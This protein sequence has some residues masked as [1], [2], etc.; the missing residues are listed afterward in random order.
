MTIIMYRSLQSCHFV[1][2]CRG[3][4]KRAQFYSQK[5]VFSAY[6]SFVRFDAKASNYRAIVGDHRSLIESKRL[7]VSINLHCAVKGTVKSV[8]QSPLQRLPP[9][10]P[11]YYV[12]ANNIISHIYVLSVRKVWLSKDVES[13]QV[14]SGQ[15]KSSQGI[16]THCRGRSIVS[17]FAGRTPVCRKVADDG[18]KGLWSINA[19]TSHAA[20]R[21]RP[22]LVP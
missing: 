21:R 6:E 1:V 12:L 19:T 22:R 16:E 18:R 8:S 13:G 15:V 20:Y 14:R 3:I 10:S 9:I 17:R 5:C 4:L 7:Y 2:H 11:I